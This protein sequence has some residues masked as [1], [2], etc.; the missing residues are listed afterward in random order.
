M[1]KF[2]QHSRMKNEEQQRVADVLLEGL[3]LSRCCLPEEGQRGQ[4]RMCK[5]HLERLQR[6][7]EFGKESQGPNSL[8]TDELALKKG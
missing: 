1:K 3:T 5:E 7:H 2:E 6:E 4:N 8:R